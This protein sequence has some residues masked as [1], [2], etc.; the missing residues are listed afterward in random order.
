M[1]ERAESFEA[2]VAA[3]LADPLSVAREAAGAGR[4]VVGYVSAEGPV[5]LI[6]AANALPVRLRGQRQSAT[7]RADEFLESAFVPEMR[8][9]AEQWL[10]G[11]LDCLDAVVFPRSHD[12]AQR[13]YYYLCELQRRGLCAGPRPLL[14]DVASIARQSS[15][16][17]TLAS[18]RL[19]AT[20]L[21]SDESR[22]AQAMQRTA[23]REASLQRLDAL[24]L[25]SPPLAGSAAH[26]ALRAAEL[27][28]NDSFDAALSG[29]LEHAPRV[30]A[31]S[32]LLLAGSAPPDDRLHR[33]VEAAGG[34][35]VREFVET[36]RAR[37][38][39]GDL[40]RAFAHRHHAARTPAQR[41][42]DSADWLAEQARAA[43]ADGVVLWL[44]EE[45][46]ALPWEAVGQARALADAGIPV[47]ALTRQCWLADAAALHA[48]GDFV[49]GLER[50]P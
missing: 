4:C 46:E 25:Q 2:V 28:W 41:M 6:L 18:A 44:I 1:N 37:A 22:L 31:R 23:R 33:A 36:E 8:A 15:L 32:R 14:F 10:T 26:R 38:A 48:L 11:A 49:A 3:L 43:R 45:D 27:D 39:G 16:E 12:S 9:V 29:W 20:S 40:M 19:L 24:R 17:H 47:L 13:L 5:E 34:A 50:T 35:I 21:G 30:A 7:P 42:L